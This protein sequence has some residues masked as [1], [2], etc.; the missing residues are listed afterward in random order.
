MCPHIEACNCYPYCHPQ[1][2]NTPE[3][4]SDREAEWVKSDHLVAPLPP[5]TE[6]DDQLFLHFHDSL[7]SLSTFTSEFEEKAFHHIHLDL[8]I[9]CFTT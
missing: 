5:A 7:I 6:L 4:R 1:S 2:K 3:L 8:V 9:L